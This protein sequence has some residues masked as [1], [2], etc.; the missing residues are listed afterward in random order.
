MK[1]SELKTTRFEV[2]ISWIPWIRQPG[3]QKNLCEPEY[4]L[5][6]IV[7]FEEERIKIVKKYNLG[8]RELWVILKGVTEKKKKEQV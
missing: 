6:E 7:Q 1:I 5:T 4:R 2:Q 3:G 8:L